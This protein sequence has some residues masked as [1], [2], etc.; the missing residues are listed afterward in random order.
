MNQ[1]KQND[2]VYWDNQATTAVDPR[3]LE[4]MLPFFCEQYGNASSLHHLF[5]YTAQTAVAEARSLLAHGIQARPEE[6]IF[7]GGATESNNLA[8]FGI[9]RAYAHRGNHIITSAIEHPAVLDP[10]AA[11]EEQGFKI[12]RLPV[13]SFGRVQVED[14]RNALEKE[15]ILV[16]VMHANNEIGTLQPIQEIGAVCRQHGVLF[17]CD[18]AQTFGK[19]D[20]QVRDMNI[21]LLSASSHKFYGP[22]G[23][24]MLF[25]SRHQPRVLLKPLMFGGGH[26]RGWRSGTANVP[27]I[28]GFA[29]AARLCWEEQSEEQYRLRKLTRRIWDELSSTIEEVHLHGHPSERL[30][31]NLNLSFAFVSAEALFREVPHVAMS[32]G[33]ACTSA[34]L[35]PSHVLRSIGI[36]DEMAAGAV[37]IS[38][39]RFNTDAEIDRVLPQIR[40]AVDRLRSQ[41]PLYEMFQARQSMS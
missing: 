18:A 23:V 5:G 11:L 35:K 39:G 17:H 3:V 28:V 40:R 7:T 20:L 4:R 8:L 16:S 37:R 1:E 30:A 12:T 21:D 14:I 41:S 33:S 15:T 25:V 6:I 34:S 26:E 31:S 19:L 9:A 22:K 13:D 38:L 29:H 27:G 32:S 36:S 10:L 2:A 24:G